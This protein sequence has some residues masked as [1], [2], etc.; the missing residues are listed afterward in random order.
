M[1]REAVEA[2]ACA[3]FT[4]AGWADAKPLSVARG[5]AAERYH[6]AHRLRVTLALH[7]DRLWRSHVVHGGALLGSGE[8]ADPAVA[9]EDA[10]M[11]AR[12]RLA[13]LVGML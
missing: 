4:A 2:T 13:V 7:P 11:A 8:D 9:M 3:I 1:T 12:E 5:A 10:V 6:G